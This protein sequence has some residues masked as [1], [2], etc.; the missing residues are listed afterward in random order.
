MVKHQLALQEEPLAAFVANPHA[1]VGDVHV[2]LQIPPIIKN[3]RA[4]LTREVLLLLKFGL[5]P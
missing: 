5:L 4:L 2:L 3:S 1:A